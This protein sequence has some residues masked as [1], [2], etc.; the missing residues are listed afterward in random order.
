MRVAALQRFFTTVRMVNHRSIRHPPFLLSSALDLRLAAP[1]DPG[2]LETLVHNAGRCSP[3]PRSDTSPAVGR[4]PFMNTPPHVSSRPST[5]YDYYRLRCGSQGTDPKH[6]WTTEGRW[7]SKSN[8]V[9]FF[10]WDEL[11]KC[12]P[13]HVDSWLKATVRASRS[14]R[15]GREFPRDRNG[16]SQLGGGKWGAKQFRVYL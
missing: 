15:S 3:P 4:F 1:W 11:R 7:L 10:V 2:Q 13:A 9:T 8:S 6:F 12:F 16:P 14:A 5:G